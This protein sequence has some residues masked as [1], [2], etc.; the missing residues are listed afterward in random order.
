ME[1]G[2]RNEMLN[3][4]TGNKKAIFYGTDGDDKIERQN[5]K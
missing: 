2:S 4:G 3:F 1:A 5:D